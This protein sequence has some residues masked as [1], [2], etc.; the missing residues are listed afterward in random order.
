MS[1]PLLTNAIGHTPD[2]E[3]EMNEVHTNRTRTAHNHT[4][5]DGTYEYGSDD[6]TNLPRTCEGKP[7]GIRGSLAVRRCGG[8]GE[9]LNVVLCF[10]RG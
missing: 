6:T 10:A 7:T 2:D 8:A 3:T 5:F 4:H 1:T 9:Y